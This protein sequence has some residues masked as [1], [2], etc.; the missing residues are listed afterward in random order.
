[1]ISFSEAIDLCGDRNAPI[2]LIDSN[3]ITASTMQFLSGLNGDALYAVKCN[4]HPAVLRAVARGGIVGFDVASIAEIEHVDSQG[5]GLPLW[6]NHPFKARSSILASHY[7]YGVTRFVVDCENEL[8]KI[9]ETLPGRKLIVQVRLAV[10][11]GSKSYDFSSKFGATLTEAISLGRQVL[12]S[13]H[14]LALCFHAGSQNEDPNSF[15]EAI[16]LL[17]SVSREVGRVPVAINVGGGF[18]GCYSGLNTPPLESYFSEIA[19]AMKRFFPAVPLVAEPGRALVADGA[20]LLCS[21]FVQQSSFKVFGPT[22]DSFDA[23]DYRFML[24]ADVAEGDWIAIS[25]MGA[26]SS[27]LRSGFNGFGS[28]AVLADTGQAAVQVTDL[29]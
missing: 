4:D 13:G 26:Y 27:V 3:A 29:V 18:P 22:C 7:E 1:M 14:D 19:H 9:N 8:N 24:P 2:L 21:S 25:E 12:D 16:E 17:G 5:L 20:V 15:A 23:L 28:L 11:S 10:K 6:F